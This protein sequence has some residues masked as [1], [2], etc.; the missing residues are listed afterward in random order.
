MDVETTDRKDSRRCSR[1]LSRKKRDK[2]EGLVRAVEGEIEGRCNRVQCSKSNR[3][4]GS[5]K[6]S[7]IM[8]DLES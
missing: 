1:R 4:R 8:G 6:E 7:K 2:R 3:L 5:V